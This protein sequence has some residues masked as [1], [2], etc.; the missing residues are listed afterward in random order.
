M[1]TRPAADAQGGVQL[2]QAVFLAVAPDVGHRV[3]RLGRTMFRTGAAVHVLPPDQAAAHVKLGHGN[4][5]GVLRDF[6]R[7]LF[8]GNG[9]LADSSGRAHFRAAVAVVKAVLGAEIPSGGFMNPLM[10]NWK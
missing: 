8:R 1:F 9:E 10:P 6:R 3:K 7:I 4:A 5:R 2:R